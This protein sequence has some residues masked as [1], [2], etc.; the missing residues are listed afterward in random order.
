MASKDTAS[1]KQ[2]QGQQGTSSSSSITPHSRPNVYQACASLLDV[3]G[4]DINRP[5]SLKTPAGPDEILSTLLRPPPQIP[6]VD[7]R[8]SKELPDSDVLKA[9]HHYAAS[10][11]DRK[12]WGD[13]AY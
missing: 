2:K 6:D 3:Q 11:Y 10:F 1:A 7:E 9:L 13:V 12:S 4:R 5:T 8:V